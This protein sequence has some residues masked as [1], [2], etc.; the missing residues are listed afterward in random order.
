MNFRVHFL[1]GGIILLLSAHAGALALLP[2]MYTNDTYN[3]HEEYSVTS[4]T[5]G[6]DGYITLSSDMVYKVN[7]VTMVTQEKTGQSYQVYHLHGGGP[8]RGTGVVHYNE[9]PISFNGPLRINSG[10]YIV[11]MY[12]RTD[13]MALVKRDRVISGVLEVD[14]VPGLGIWINFGN[15]DI[16]ES[17][18][19]DPP[20][21]DLS[22]PMEVGNVWD[23]H[24][25]IYAFGGF[26]TSLTDPDTFDENITINGHGEVL[27]RVNIDT[28]QGPC[29]TYDIMVEDEET[30]IGIHN[31]YCC[32]ANWILAQ[33]FT[34]LDFFGDSITVERAGMEITNYHVTDDSC[35]LPTP[36]PT[37]S[38]C[39]VEACE[40]ADT[41]D[42][43]QVGAFE[44]L[45]FIDL[46]FAGTVGPFDVL[47]SIDCYFSGSNTCK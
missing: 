3:V 21:M 12:M 16:T 2:T 33:E 18:E 26:D 37:P 46:Y 31:N 24:L 38:A 23:Q 39:V 28:P 20:L 30:G 44:L 45:A 36:T 1:T 19:Y 29:E 13:T 47:N 5:I 6:K 22:F 27:G 41:D 10:T 43:G 9:P 42:S 40:V 17:E 34:G 11:D 8:L 35:D 32:S 14:A 7:G 25:T 4:P 15:A